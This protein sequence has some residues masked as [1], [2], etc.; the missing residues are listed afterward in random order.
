MSQLLGSY[1]FWTYPCTRADPESFQTEN[2]NML[3]YALQ[4]A[5]PIRCP[6]E[7]ELSKKAIIP[8]SYHAVRQSMQLLP[9]VATQNLGLP[10]CF[11]K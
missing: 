5:H 7:S 9:F 11:S 1:I 6:G 4:P 8:T 10:I 2:W 3:R